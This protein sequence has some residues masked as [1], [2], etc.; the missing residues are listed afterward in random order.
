MSSRA[1]ERS[2]ATALMLALALAA[3]AC[4]STVV[5]IRGSSMLPTYKDGDTAIGSKTVGAIARG[6]VVGFRY[7]R[8]E[9]KSF[10]QRVVGLPGEEI[11]IVNGIVSI[12]G[13]PIPEPYVAPQNNPSFSMS[14]RRI[15]DD[16]YFMLGDNRGNSSDSRSWGNVA[17]GKIWMKLAK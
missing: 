10:V 15:P 8:D 3:A 4:D 9:S 7:P 17:R 16:L 11:E 1:S 12:N 13:K 5:T 14:R 2:T 6:D